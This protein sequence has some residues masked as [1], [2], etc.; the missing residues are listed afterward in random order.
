M[1]GYAELLDLRAAGWARRVPGL[2]AG[3]R[4]IRMSAGTPIILT[5]FSLFSSVSPGKLQDN[6]WNL[7]RDTFLPVLWNSS[8]TAHSVWRL[9]SE[10]YLISLNKPYAINKIATENFLNNCSLCHEILLD[11][12]VGYAI[13]LLDSTVFVSRKHSMA[14]MNDVALIL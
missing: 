1:T 12:S 13:K 9:S 11:L 4:L 7:A 10:R 3:G 2:D 6:T 8:F 14:L 5:D